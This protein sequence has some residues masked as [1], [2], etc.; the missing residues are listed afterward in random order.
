MAPTAAVDPSR[1]WCCGRQ[2]RLIVVKSDD[3]IW[4]TDPVF[5]IAS[6]WEGFKAKREQDNTNVFRI[7][8]GV[9]V[10]S[11]QGKPLAFIRLP[12]RCENLT[13]GGPK[14]NR[15]YMAACHSIYALHV[16]AHGAT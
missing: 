1:R 13:F 9:M 3:T 2:A 4:F 7:G 8:A 5:G 15:L 6:E 10:F 14:N 16:E 11:A 12:E